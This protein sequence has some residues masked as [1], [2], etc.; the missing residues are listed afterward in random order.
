MIE[1]EFIT[2]IRD[3][4]RTEEFRALK[5]H[6]HHVKGSV[7]DHSVKVAYLC[8]KHHKLFS[9]RT[10][11][12]ELVRGALLHDFYLYDRSRGRREHRFHWLR[13][14]MIALRNA[15]DRY[16]MLTYRQRD[17]IRRHMFPLTIT[18]PKTAAGWLVCFYD[19]LAAVS[20]RFGRD[21]WAAAER[22]FGKKASCA[23]SSGKIFSNISETFPQQNA[24]PAGVK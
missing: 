1:R 7:Y 20:D 2:I 22:R 10:D 17:M 15:E 8:Y 13:H 16:P 4:T 12:G 21:R 23:G 18:P 19:K 5:T 3:I 6:R 9:M 14:P 24:K 11:L